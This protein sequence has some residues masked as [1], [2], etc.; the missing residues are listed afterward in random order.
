M[1][2][3]KV[4]P[5]EAVLW[6]LNS[7]ASN[8]TRLEAFG[9]RRSITFTV[10]PL[11]GLHDRYVQP[12]IRDSTGILTDFP[13][14]V[15]DVAV[16][17]ALQTCIDTGTQSIIALGGGSVLDAAKAVS[18]LHHER[19]GRFLPIAALP[20]TLSG[21][22]FSHYFGITQADGPQ[23]FKKSFACRDTVPK[24]VLIDP[25]LIIGTPRPLVLSSAIK[26][27]DHAVEGMRKVNTDHP[28]AIMAAS[29]VERFFQVLQTW[30]EAL[31]TRQAVEQGLVMYEDLLKLQ[32][33]AWQCYF[34]PASVIYGLSHRI[35]HILGGTF[36]VPHSA[37]SCITLASVLRACGE[38]YGDKLSFF[39]GGRSG[40]DA[41][42][43]LSGRIEALVRSLGLPDRISA[44]NLERSV[45]PVVARLLRENYKEEVA[46]LGRE[47]GAKLEELLER[48]W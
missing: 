6:G 34:Y 16:R 18:Y 44:F 14:H 2:E 40:I 43:Y 37:T 31:E 17:R 8:V 39:A 25:V 20:T 12:N 45:L 35:G 4:L 29:G 21:S 27:I 22:E 1:S 3:L 15:P 24:V 7:L 46:D 19:T 28:H 32:L 11:R 36:N 42:D 26:G 10:E 30:P 23:K 13:P 5:Q 47:S 9:I 41:A 33:A 48:L 38:L